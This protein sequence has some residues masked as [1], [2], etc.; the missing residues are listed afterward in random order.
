MNSANPKVGHRSFR[1]LMKSF[2]AIGA[3]SALML[4]GLAFVAESPASAAAPLIFGGATTAQADA[5]FSFTVT[6]AASGDNINVASTCPFKAGSVTSQS[7][8]GSDVATFP[9][10]SIDVGSSCTL[11]ASDTTGID[12][13]AQGTVVF[14]VTPAAASKIAYTTGPPTA[15]TLG[16]PLTTF[17]VSVEDTYGNVITIGTG[18]SDTVTLTSGCTLAGTDTATAGAGV[19]TFSY[20]YFTAGTSCTLIATDGGFTVTSPSITVVSNTPTELGFTIEP[21]ATAAAGTVLPSFV[22][23]VEASNGVALQGGVGATDVIVLTSACVL[24]GTTSVTA[25]NDAATFAA[26]A[27]KTGSNCQLVATDTSRTLATATSTVVALTAGAA[28]QVAFTTA[29]PAAVTTAGTVLTTFRVSV[30]DVNGN[31]VTLGTGAGD[32]IA[33][34]SPCTLGGTTTAVAFAGV[35]TFSALTIGVTGACVLTATDT[36][37][38]LAAAT[39]TSTVGTP[40]PALVLSTVKGTVGTALNLATTGGTGTGALS[41]TVGAGS[42][43]GCTESGTSLSATRAGTCLVTATKAGSTT[44]IAVSSAATTVTFV[45][46][47]KAI[48]VAGTVTVGKTSTV[49]I[50]G[51]GFSGQPR[52]ICN[53]AGVTARVAGDS[54]RT[55]RV[56]VKVRAGVKT[57]VHTFT[58][59][60]ANGKRTSVKFSLR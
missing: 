17:K 36:T 25:V 30:E 40:Q 24:T 59:I 47:L 32:S 50:V 31:V 4:A 16:V 22:V 51:S 1:T 19:A 52:I 41:Y 42:S 5:P 18:A 35:A 21:P 11:T 3:T 33:I 10:M 57:G 60:L 13:G 58:V 38:T 55:L 56:I 12:S 48:R 49:T 14:T 39:A 9:G 7:T 26:V 29:P 23:S 20:V 2:V 6:A 8:N 46:P 53:V 15:G 43:A 34:T 27:I 28:T 45:L 44:Y 37:R 54:G